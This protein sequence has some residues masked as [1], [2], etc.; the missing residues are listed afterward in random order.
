MA[1][2]EFFSRLAAGRKPKAPVRDTDQYPRLTNLGNLGLMNG[3][4]AQYKPTPPN[5]RYFSRTPYART[6]INRIKEPM[7]SLEWEITPLAGIKAN[8]HLDKQI[9]VAMDCFSHPNSDDSWRTLVGQVI[10]DWLVFGAGVIEQQLGGDMVR[11]LWMWPVDAQSIQIFPCWSGGRDEARYMQTIGYTN[12]GML[13]GRKLRNDEIIYIKANDSTESPYGFGALEIAFNTVNRLLGVAEFTGNLASNAQP[14]IMLHFSDA[15][16][17]RL[18]AFRSYWR[19]EVEGQ[20]VTPMFGGKNEPKSIPLH[21]GGDGALYL[22]YQQFVIREIATAFGLSPQNLGIEADVNRST[23][24]V[25]AD[26][27]WDN[28]IIPLAELFASYITRETLHAKL[29]FY[30]IE[31][32]FKGLYREDEESTSKIYE[33]YYKNN[34]ITPN[35]QRLK[36][37]LDPL[38]N[39][40]A[41]KPFADTQIALSAARGSAVIEDKDLDDDQVTTKKVPNKKLKD[42]SKT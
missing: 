34:A 11:P 18:R 9:Q 16:D 2:K 42:E 20:G 21:P 30:Q 27:D 15:D 24:E 22:E 4:K 33:T 40:W 1:I 19:N 35:E 5:I 12:V 38:V 25:A 41:D 39:Q 36:M 31:F 3:R 23:A 28:T 29:G 32:K 13:E 17:E 6:A 7:K 10:E 37:G 26:R 14:Q 8:Q